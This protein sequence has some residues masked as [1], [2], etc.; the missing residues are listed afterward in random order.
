[1]NISNVEDIDQS[2]IENIIA[3]V[4]SVDLK[5]PDVPYIP[6]DEILIGDGFTRL[7]NIIE[8]LFGK[9]AA[10][11]ENDIQVPNFT[12]V[13]LENS[14]NFLNPVKAYNAISSSYE[15][16]IKLLKVKGSDHFR[17]SFMFHSCCMIERSLK[18]EPLPYENINELIKSKPELY[19]NIKKSLKIVEETFGTKIPDKEIGYLM[20]L[21]KAYL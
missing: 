10:E 21:V 3:I 8:N 2:K 16:V 13:M 18:K 4:G 11:T 9:Q 20:D 1:M 14:L 5:I 15:E 12:A 17:I 7:K 19:K 6:I